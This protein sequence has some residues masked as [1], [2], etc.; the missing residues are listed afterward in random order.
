M[1]GLTR[2]GVLGWLATVTTLTAGC[3]TEAEGPPDGAVH[4]YNQTNF[5]R[6]VRVRVARAGGESLLDQTF[7]V[8]AGGRATSADVMP[9]AGD[10]EVSAAS[11]GDRSSRTL[12]FPSDGAGIMGYVRVAISRDG[13]L[14]SRA[15]LR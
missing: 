4:C 11:D 1:Q 10:Y 2:R 15:G 14:V 7:S 13:V 6:S 12:T 3:S 5:E 8:P 9:E